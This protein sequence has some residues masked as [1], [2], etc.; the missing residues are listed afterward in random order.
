MKKIWRIAFLL[1]FAFIIGFSFS[2]L[3]YLGYWYRFVD[4]LKTISWYDVPLWF[5]LSFII[6]LT[7]HEL[8]HLFMMVFQGIRIR[9]LYLY[10]F[11]FYQSK[12]G[13]R[14][15]FKPKFWYLLGGFVVPDLGKIEHDDQYQK[16]IDKFS[17]ALLA[18][19]IVTISFLVLTVITFIL[20]IAYNWNDVFIGIVTLFSFFTVVFSTLFIRS[21]KL[22]NASFY[23][24]F[25]AYHKMQDDPIFQIVEINQYQGFSLI[26]SSETEKYLF[27]KTKQILK[28]TELKVTL[29]HQMAI[30]SYIEGVCYEGFDDDLIVREKIM[31]YPIHPNYRNEQGLALLYDIALYYYHLGMVEKSYKLMEEIPRK[32]STKINEKMRVYLEKKYQHILHISYDELFLSKKENYVFFMSG[33]FDELMDMEELTRLMHEKR[34]LMPWMT[35]IDLK[36]DEKTNDPT[37]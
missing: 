5:V 33:L 29:F 30:L 10:M 22:S 16:I 2:F 13:L 18:G 31:R 32:A 17:R 34:P 28:E 24:D 3:V 12:K 26:E 6:S 23:G 1:V 20:S 4:G 36:E 25:V 8:G 11:M 14:I 35:T 7:V 37:Q 21:F 9:A 19:P 15:K 27:D